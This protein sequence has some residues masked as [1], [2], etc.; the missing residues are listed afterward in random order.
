MTAGSFGLNFA[1]NMDIPAALTSKTS[2]SCLWILCSLTAVCKNQSLST[3][4]KFE[5]LQFLMTHF[6]EKSKPEPL[7]ND[8]MKHIRLCSGNILN[9]VV[10][11]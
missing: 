8:E 5:F 6:R 3:R 10:S 4:R 1:D 9:I 2:L 7:K 11:I